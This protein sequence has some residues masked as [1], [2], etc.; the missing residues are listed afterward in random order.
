MDQRDVLVADPLDVVFSE[1]VVEHGGAFEGL[2]GHDAGTV[3]RLEPF[4]SRQGSSRPGG[5]HEGGQSKLRL[6]PLVV[7]V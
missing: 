5:G 4:A 7:E 3:V 1:A 2:D 6:L